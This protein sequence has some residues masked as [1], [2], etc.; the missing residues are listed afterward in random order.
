[1]HLFF[2]DYLVLL[3]PLIF[4]G[5]AFRLIYLQQ[6]F[7]NIVLNNPADDFSQHTELMLRM[8]RQL[9]INF[10]KRM[11]PYIIVLMIVLYMIGLPI[12]LPVLIAGTVIMVI[13]IWLMLQTVGQ[14]RQFINR[15]QEPNT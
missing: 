9:E 3:S 10:C 6:R 12:H 15:T 13:A 11:A 2:L 4:L 5:L 7:I 1:M 8:N 14:F